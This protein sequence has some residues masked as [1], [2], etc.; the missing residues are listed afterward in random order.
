MAKRAERADGEGRVAPHDEADLQAVGQ[1]MGCAPEALELSVSWEPIAQFIDEVEAMVESYP[2]LPKEAARTRRIER[3]LSKG[4]LPRPVYV[5]RGEVFVMEGRHRIV[6]F[7]RAGMLEVPVCRVA[8]GP[9]A[10]PPKAK[11][12]KGP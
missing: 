5:E 3:L 1:W 11:G 4:E 10:V 7:A 12:P 6:A 2:R 8:R 9:K